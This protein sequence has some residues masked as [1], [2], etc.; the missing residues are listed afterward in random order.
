MGAASSFPG[1]LL[2]MLLRLPVDWQ[3]HNFGAKDVSG[4]DAAGTR[5]RSGRMTTIALKPS[6]GWGWESM[7]GR[8]PG[9]GQALREHSR[10]MF[11]MEHLCRCEYAYRSV[12][13]VS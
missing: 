9:L 10:E 2:E 8:L 11:H 12:F 3:S 1:A 6:A 4:I 5:A 7:A 13:Y